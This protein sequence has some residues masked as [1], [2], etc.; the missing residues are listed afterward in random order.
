MFCYSMENEKSLDQSEGYYDQIGI[1]LEFNGFFF[2]IQLRNFEVFMRR[3]TDNS[4]LRNGKKWFV[5]RFSN[6]SV[7]IILT[8][9]DDSS[10]GIRL[11][12]ILSSST[13]DYIK[14]VE[15]NLFK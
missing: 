6:V 7:Y 9:D 8:F 4:C 11:L 1:L 2:K 10:L 3:T 5:S 13:K 12:N 15:Y 14:F